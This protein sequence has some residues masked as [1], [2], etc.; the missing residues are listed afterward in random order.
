VL[1][2]SIAYPVDSCVIADGWIHWVNHDDVEPLV[3]T[4]L[5]NPV[6]VQHTHGTNGLA[7]TL[8]SM[9]A[10][11]T[12]ILE[13]NDTD[14]SWLTIPDLVLALPDT[15]TS[16]D[17]DTIDHI[18]LLGFVTDAMSLFWARWAFETHNGWELSEFPAS[19]TLHVVGDF[20]G[21]LSPEFI[22]IFISTHKYTRKEVD[23]IVL[24][25][26]YYKYTPF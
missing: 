14:I 11:L 8:F 3:V 23:F 25:Y 22:D 9:D 4:V 7:D 19:D 6:R 24:I 18:T 21:F 2:G 10:E 26:T 17:T 12:V 13:S 16:P 20:S 15:T 1:V 5:G